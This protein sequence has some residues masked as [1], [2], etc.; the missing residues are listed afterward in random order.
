MAQQAFEDG[1]LK[2]PRIVLRPEEAQAAAQRHHLK[3]VT[4]RVATPT[5]QALAP[6]V[7]LCFTVRCSCMRRWP[8]M[9]ML[10][11]G[12]AS[13]SRN[14]CRPPRRPQPQEF[15]AAADG[16]GLASVLQAAAN[17][18]PGWRIYLLTY[19]AD[20]KCVPSAA[21]AAAQG[22][23]A[24]DAMRARLWQL[25]ADLAVWRP[26]VAF[27]N[28]ADL[29]GAAQHMYRLSRAVAEL[30]GGYKRTVRRGR[31]RVC[32]LLVKTC[33]RR[34]QSRGGGQCASRRAAAC[35]P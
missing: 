7:L 2:C 22:D 18:H 3:T 13:A 30:V 16:D 5:G 21:A 10:Q 25:V 19:E 20:S 11:A 32:L 15:V 29:Q 1:T 27:H 31:P 12:A 4:W 34:L 8:R 14:C 6:H 17:L 9:C 33:E 26:D 24:A 35:L 28:A 23:A